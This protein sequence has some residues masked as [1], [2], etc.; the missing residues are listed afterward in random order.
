MA[1][2][3]NIDGAG[4]EFDDHAPDSQQPHVLDAVVADAFSEEPVAAIVEEPL[5]AVVEEPAP[6]AAAAAAASAPDFYAVG[7]RLIKMSPVWL[8][9]VTGGFALLILLLSW[10]RP[11]GGEVDAASIP[12]DA[13]AVVVQYPEAP[14]PTAAKPSE[15]THAPVAAPSKEERAEVST[16]TKA[17]APV[18]PASA[19]EESHEAAPVEEKKQAASVAH[20]SGDAGGKFTVQVGS[21]SVESQ[22]NER[23]SSLRAAGFDARSTAVEIPGRGRWFR[24]HVGRFVGREEAAKVAAQL[25]EKG[26]ASGSMVVPVQ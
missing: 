10:V 2:E 20:S 15:E 25:R 22:A 9:T 8:L 18:Q 19:P 4:V 16:E 11:A 21:F 5:A 6:V 17:A 14:A 26:A 13:K 1:H 7:V 23:I 12:N 24:V 3:E